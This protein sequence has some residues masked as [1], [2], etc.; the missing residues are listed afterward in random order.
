MGVDLIIYVEKSMEGINVKYSVQA[1]K[2]GAAILKKTAMICTQINDLVHGTP[3]TKRKRKDRELI[4]EDLGV[5][6]WRKGRKAKKEGIHLHTLEEQ[7][8]SPQTGTD[9][10]T[11][12]RQKNQKR[13]NSMKGS[14]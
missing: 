12:I 3:Q 11:G 4:G 9:L 7:V 14:T 5:R 13:T 10:W 8:E 1:V 2:S 6:V